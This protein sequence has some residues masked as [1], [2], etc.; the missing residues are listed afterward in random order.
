MAKR[1][2]TRNRPNKEWE[3][4]EVQIIGDEVRTFSSRERQ[5][6]PTNGVWHRSFLNIPSNFADQRVIQ[7]YEPH[8]NEPEY[9]MRLISENPVLLGLILTKCSILHGDGL[10]LMKRDE[11][12]KKVPVPMEDW[13]E[14]IR[15]FYEYNELDTWSYQSFCDFETLGNAFPHIIFTKGSKRFPKKVGE[16]NRIP[17]DCVRALRPKNHFSDIDQYIVS[18]KWEELINGENLIR[19]DAYKRKAFYE[20]RKFVAGSTKAASVLW[21][22]KRNLPGYPFYGIPHWYG[23]RY[24]VEMQNEIPLLHIANIINQWGARMQVSV[25]RKYIDSRRALVNPETKMKYTD[26]EIKEEISKTIRD[27][28]TKPENTGRSIVSAHDFDHQGR[29]LKDFVI[30]MIKVDIKDDAYSKLEELIH[31][32]ITSSVGVQAQLASLITEKGMSSGSEMTQAWNIEVTKARTTQKMVLKPIEFIHKYNGWSKEYSWGFVN[33][34][35][36]TKDIDKAGIVEQ[37]QGEPKQPEEK[38]PEDKKVNGAA[39]ISKK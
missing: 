25:S 37:P 12:G 3:S 14:E 22:I 11:S 28:F 31:S 13:P 27:L 9:L 1:F 30:E 16:I 17:P 8:N 18:S 6:A 21:H 34:F 2:D 32:K 19:L 7:W 24:Y 35:L 39:V 20:N 29:I 5:T 23:A 26:R 10:S 4:F 33:P 36:V 38:K 15:E